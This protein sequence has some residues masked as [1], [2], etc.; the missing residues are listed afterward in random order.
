MRHVSPQARLMLLGAE[1]AQSTEPDSGSLCTLARNLSGAASV[2]QTASGEG[3]AVPFG[4]RDLVHGALPRARLHLV[5]DARAIV[6]APAR[7]P[8]P[9][10]LA[11]AS[12]PGAWYGAG[13]K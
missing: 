9:R 8:G 13:R 11:Q 7:S 12:C 1:S 10:P 4:A 2:S 6:H 5:G 3:C